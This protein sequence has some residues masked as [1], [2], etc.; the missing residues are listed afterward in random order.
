MKASMITRDADTFVSLGRAV[1]LAATE[2]A[3]DPESSREL[4]AALVAGILTGCMELDTYARVHDALARLLEKTFEGP[5][6]AETTPPAGAPGDEAEAESLDVYLEVV[7]EA[8]EKV[9]WEES[10]GPLK[11]FV[12]SA[13]DLDHA[14]FGE[15]GAWFRAP[16]QADLDSVLRR[17]RAAG[18]LVVSV[19]GGGS[20]AP[21]EAV[22]HEP[23]AATPPA[24][25]VLGWGDRRAALDLM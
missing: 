5:S 10:C 19:Q 6:T 25:V 15:K 2:G 18:L 21:S 23:D 22:L 13:F 16:L 3:L 20:G 14:H 1:N 9:G 4:T 24:R 8:W 11:E 12:R 7:G 17:A